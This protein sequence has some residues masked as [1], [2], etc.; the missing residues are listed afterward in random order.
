MRISNFLFLASLATLPIQLGKFFWSKSSF[1]LGIP[2]D[3]LAVSLYLSDLVIV[4]YLVAFFL[5]NFKNLGKIYR[6]RKTFFVSLVLLN[7]YVLLS[8]LF[9][10]DNKLASLFFSLKLFEFGT[11]C[12]FLSFTISDKKIHKL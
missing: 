4:A 9:V 2:I 12:Y 5:E 10:S 1:V 6:N 11:F 8:G 7:L 3:Y